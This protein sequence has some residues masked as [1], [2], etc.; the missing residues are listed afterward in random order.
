V[1]LTLQPDNT[2]IEL[3]TRTRPG[4]EE[5][6]RQTFDQLEQAWRGVG[7]TDLKTQAQPDGSY[8]IQLS[9]VALRDQVALSQ[10]IPSIA[11]WALLRSLLVSVEPT[12]QRKS[13]L[14]W[15]DVTI[16]QRVDLRPVADQW[17][18]IGALLERQA[19]EA[20]QVTNI[21]QAQSIESAEAQI[22][23]QLRQIYLQHEA[24]AWQNL[25]RASTVQ[26]KMQA[27]DRDTGRTWIVQLTDP[28]QT[29]NFHT[30]VLSLTRLLLSILSLLILILALA[31]VLWLLL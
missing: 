7:V 14:I 11:D 16:A 26:V 31:G 2:V 13:R 3:A 6:A 25:I 5:I 27:T 1:T 29:V 23:E 30:E 20:R 12:I 18:G 28:Q 22:R 9:N 10:A 8:L 15:Q 24:A 4:R 19:T 21:G 17:R